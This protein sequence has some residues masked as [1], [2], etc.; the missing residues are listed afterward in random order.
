MVRVQEVHSHVEEVYGDD[1]E[2]YDDGSDNYTDAEEELSE[3]GNGASEEARAS[4][5]SHLLRPSTWS[6]GRRRGGRSSKSLM[7]TLVEGIGVAVRLS[8]QITWIVT[9]SILLVGLPLLYAYDREKSTQEEQLAP[10]TAGT[11]DAAQARPDDR[12][13]K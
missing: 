7:S 1:G 12:A 4:F 9:T 6:W 10:L 5:W 8:G 2:E 13:R 3:G 11:V